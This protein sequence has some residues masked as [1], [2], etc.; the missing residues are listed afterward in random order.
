MLAYL[1][2]VDNPDDNLSAARIINVPKRGIGAGSV[3]KLTAYALEYGLSFM[4]AVSMAGQ[5]K[6]LGRSAGKVIAFSDEI[7]KLV[8]MAREGVSPA[9]LIEHVYD[10]MGY[11]KEI[12]KD[13][14]AAEERE[15]NI[16]ELIDR[17][18]LYES[19]TGRRAF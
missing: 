14:G 17:A 19:E 6:E 4:D 16:Q 15:A 18:G 7:D 8:H 5:N 3:E 2:V 1:K 12:E 13:I 9:H 10:K 11:R